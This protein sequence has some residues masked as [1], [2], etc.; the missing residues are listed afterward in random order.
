MRK[1]S[2]KTQT[3]NFLSVISCSSNV[4]GCCFRIHRIG[5]GLI[6]LFGAHTKIGAVI[7]VIF[8]AGVQLRSL[9]SFKLESYPFFCLLS[10]GGHIRCHCF[11][12]C[13]ENLGPP[14]L[15]FFLFF[16]THCNLYV[17]FF[18][19]LFFFYLLI[20]VLLNHKKTPQKNK[21]T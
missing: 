3:L 19:L 9:L 8:A 5:S 16:F 17:C 12:T 4:F 21:P 2:E 11:Y 1:K 14:V 7:F 10:Q 6:P 13:T 20:Y 18:F 15:F